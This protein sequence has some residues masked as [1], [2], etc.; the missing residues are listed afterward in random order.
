MGKRKNNRGQFSIIAALLVAVILVAAVVTTYS[1]I[2]YG[3]SE[4]EPQL[5]SATDETNQ[6]LKQVLG[7]TVG[8]YGSVLQV[9]GNSSYAQTL[10]ANYLNGGLQNIAQVRPDWASSFNVTSL[11]L[12][13]N[14]FLNASYST[15]QLSVI[16]NLAGL[17]VYGVSYTA[18]CRL[19]VYVSN[20]PGT[21][22][23]SLSVVQ[24][25]TQPLINLGKQN[26]N[27]YNYT[28]SNMTWQLASPNS[29][30]TTFTN[31]T[32]TINVPTGVDPSAYLVQVKDSRGI[33]VI[34]SSFN[35]YS[36]AFNWNMTSVTGG[37]YVD[38]YNSSIDGIQDVGTHNSFSAQQNGPDGSFD[39]LTEAASGTSQQNY[40]VYPTGSFNLIGS[41]YVASGSIN[42]L[43][44]DDGNLMTFGS[45]GTSTSP[46][47]LYVHQEP[48]NIGIAPYSLSPSS[49]DA[50]GTTLSATMSNSRVFLGQAL[51]S[52]Q[53]LSTIPASTWTMN[54]RAWKDT[55]STN[56]LTNSPRID[57]GSWTNGA[58]AY[59]SGGGYASSPPVDKNTRMADM[60]SQYRPEPP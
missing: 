20:S 41:T 5:L 21:N 17:G 11:S 3:T 23:V 12:G 16:Y 52:L 30:P 29:D 59:S 54:Y 14:W 28:Y 51:Y 56:T 55:S 33:I 50:S 60:V 25:G 10:A 1:T 8:Y 18:S 15:G 49:S 53:G 7:F 47:T 24:D 46:Q 36:S 4:S 35:H 39:T 38:S 48:A 42:N 58:N 32:Y 44:S 6:A 40:F 43:Q 9:T 27:F 22:Q 31:G 13:T 26:F 37:N 2:R 34:A 45:Y 19:D 57:S